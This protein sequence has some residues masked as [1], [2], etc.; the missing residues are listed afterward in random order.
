M[1]TRLTDDGHSWP[2]SRAALTALL[3][4]LPAMAVFLW[5]ASRYGSWLIDDAGISF[6]YARDL[7]GGFGLTSQPGRDPVEGFSNPLWTFA[8]AALY[9]LKLFSLPLAPKLVACVLVLGAFVA[10][11]SAVLQLMGRGDAAMVAGFSL[12]MSAANPGFVIWCVSGL[13]NPLLVLLA[14][15]L[16]LQA[17]HALRT[18]VKDLGVTC[19]YAGLMAAGLALTRPDGLVY[20]IVFPAACALRAGPFQVKPFLGSVLLYG[21]CAAIP[22]GSYILFRHFYFSDWL[23]NTYYAKP[24]LSLRGLSDVVHMWGP[25]GRRFSELAGAIFPALPLL[26]LILLLATVGLARGKSSRVAR[27]ILLVGL[28]VALSFAVYV[29]LPQDWM[30]EYRF[31]TVAF[32]FTYLL[33]FLILR[34][35]L[36]ASPWISA[37][38]GMLLLLGAG[39]VIVSVPEF[40]VRSLV[41]ADRPAAPLA[42]VAQD[43]YRFN[44][45]ADALT[46]KNPSLLA[47]DLG[48]T[49]LVSR[50]RVIDLAGLC[51]RE[52]GRLYHD[53]VPRARFADY[54]LTRV[55]PDFVYVHHNWTTRSGLLSDD[56]FLATYLDLGEGAFV[57]R[58]SLP[59]NLNDA[60]VRAIV[61]RLGSAPRPRAEQF[62]VPHLEP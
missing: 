2:A 17:V 11:T 26:A 28:I 16:L 49:L 14:T 9:S 59:A 25:G 12:L 43:A 41:F 3:V 54:I 30:G 18:D 15:G 33:C 7:A 24:G 4:S 45:L 27:E 47:P 48:A 57:R 37:K 55:K 44:E 62:S 10:F 56:E 60:G 5:H 38:R 20:A 22:F 58:A 50:L 46:V 40:L 34:H 8:L 53:N 1:D 51:D 19:V 42:A 31:A 52:I 32:P 21:L 61:A 39:L 13:E 35:A 6:A 36:A 29:T 23:P